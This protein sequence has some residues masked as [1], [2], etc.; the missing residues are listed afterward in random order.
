LFL[1]VIL[2]ASSSLVLAD[3]GMWLFNAAP[4]AKIKVKY[5]FLPTQPW[6]DHVRL[7]SVRFNNGGSGSFVSAEGLTFTNHHVG[8]TCIHGLSTGGKDYMKTGFYARTQADEARCPDLELNVLT[9][10][11]DVTGKV[12]AAVKPNMPAAQAGQAQ[13]A[14][15]AS[16]ESDCTR[17]T[18]L[19]CDVVTLYS[20]QMF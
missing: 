1:L 17:S 4:V 16:I 20:G 15:M 14:A 5:G 18:G 6:L 8:A 9:G 3:E 2:V 11:E 12:N 13:R 7:S 19:R 10:I